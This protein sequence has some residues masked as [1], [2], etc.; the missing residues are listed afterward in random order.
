[1]G[2]DIGMLMLCVGTGIAQSTIE[3]EEDED[4]E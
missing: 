3:G 4:D 2:G 1:M